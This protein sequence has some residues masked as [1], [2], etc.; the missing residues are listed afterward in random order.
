LALLIAAAKSNTAWGGETPPSE[1]EPLKTE[2][3]CPELEA[4]ANARALPAEFFVR[5]IWKESRFNPQ[6]VSPKGAEGIAQFMPGTA[7]ER[8]LEDPFDPM[9]AIAESASY[10]ADL[11]AELGNV[12][13]AAA[14]YN[15]GPDRVRDWLAGRSTLPWETVDYVQF[16]TGRPVEDWK[17]ADTV[18][19]KLL[20]DGQSLQE[21]CHALPMRKR[22]YQPIH[23]SQQATSP[24]RPWGVQLAAHF[25]RDA[26]L[27]IYARLRKQYASVLAE[28]A[29][30]VIRHR[31][32]GFGRKSRYAVRVGFDS[33]AA[34]EKLC[35]RLRARGGAC[36]VTKN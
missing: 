8:G 10:L 17:E 25:N 2:V 9:T 23:Q 1:T 35:D 15:A 21:W 6:A 3:L 31:N 33:L 20:E 19:P 13:L 12:G 26:A 7:A 11:A 29:P 27:A 32:P 34:A 18:L 5:L 36:G 24:R 14:A 30:T 28:Q 22:I 16:I 4:Q